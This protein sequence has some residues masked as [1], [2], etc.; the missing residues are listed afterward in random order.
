MA[1]FIASLIIVVLTATLVAAL[2]PEMIAIF[3][4]RHY[5]GV[6][7]YLHNDAADQMRPGDW[8]WVRRV[9]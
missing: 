9:V 2:S 1:I 8:A 3:R 5:A 7:R 6:H 4:D